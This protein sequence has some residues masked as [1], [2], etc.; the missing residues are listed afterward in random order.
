MSDLSRKGIAS[1]AALSALLGMA[2]AARQ[3]ADA[4]LPSGSLRATMFVFTLLCPVLLGA[5]IG[6]WGGDRAGAWGARGV[7]GAYWGVVGWAWVEAGAFPVGFHL[8]GFQTPLFVTVV[9]ISIFLMTAYFMQALGR[10]G[11]R[12]GARR[13]GARPRTGDSR[14]VAPDHPHL[15]PSVPDV[16]TERSVSS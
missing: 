6:V 5:A 7:G 2:V 4:G 15:A 14:S 3:L 8:Q 16:T 12:L 13:V 11:G 1:A 9:N 10:S